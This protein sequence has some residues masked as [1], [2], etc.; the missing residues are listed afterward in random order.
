MRTYITVCGV[1]QRMT[2]N[3]KTSGKAYDF[4]PMSFTYDDPYG[5]TR[6]VLADTVNVPGPMFAAQPINP[7]DVLDV[8]MHKQN[9][10]NVIDAIL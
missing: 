9:Y 7:G 6:G 2:G 10:R 3:A 5:S 4:V 1:G 8:V